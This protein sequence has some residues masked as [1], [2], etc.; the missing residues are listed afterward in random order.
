MDNNTYN[1]FD[2]TE[3]NHS[4]KLN[5]LKICKECLS[6]DF[7][8][9]REGDFRDVLYVEVCKNCKTILR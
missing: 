4:L 3:K 6:R 9:H 5:D 7:E 8:T 2:P 1:Y